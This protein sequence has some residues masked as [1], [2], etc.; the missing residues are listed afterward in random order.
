MLEY[1]ESIFHDV[2]LHLL[3]IDAVDSISMVELI[4]M[5]DYIMVNV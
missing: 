5:D 4:I 3:E 1:I 2:F